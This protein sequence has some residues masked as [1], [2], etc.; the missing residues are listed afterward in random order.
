MKITNNKYFQD[1]KSKKEENLI[2]NN[3]NVNINNNENISLESIPFP[4]TDDINNLNNYSI[5]Y[6]SSLEVPF[7]GYKTSPKKN[8]I[9]DMFQEEKKK[10]GND[11]N[12]IRRAKK[13]IFSSLL[14]YNNDVILK[15]YNNSIG[16]GINIKKLLK[17]SYNHIK[18]TSAIFNNILLR[19][20]Q[21]DIFSENISSRHTNYPL[22]HNR[23]IINKLLNETDEDKR[24]R[25]KNLFSRT[26]LDCIKHCLGIQK[27][28][29]L[30][31]L[32]IVFKKE[33]DKLDSSEEMKEELFN[34][35]SN[36]EKIFEEKRPRKRK[37]KNRNQ[38]YEE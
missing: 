25:F 8:S 21:G 36:I 5:Y 32:E 23:E 3:I 9:E 29:G 27:I 38:I 19:K 14:K 35:L 31:G 30:E 28:E 33:I 37:K 22:N 7:L 16:N 18:D 1:K 24:V 10:N 13:V 34:I 26:L 12:L 17:T 15:A 2:L 20:S 4:I 6:P 11:D